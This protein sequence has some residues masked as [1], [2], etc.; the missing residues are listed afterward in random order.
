MLIFANIYYRAD[1]LPL[2]L[3]LFIGLLSAVAL[4]LV[5]DALMWALDGLAGTLL[6]IVTVFYYIL[7]S[8][9]CLLWYLYVEYYIHRDT[10]RLKKRLFP[11]L[12]PT[13]I[14]LVFSLMS[15]FGDFL[16]YID[17]D[18]VYHRGRLFFL[19]V[20][21]SLFYII[22]TII[23][24]IRC[25]KF[26][27]K[28]DIIPLNIFMIPPAVGAVLQSMYF[29][30]SLIWPL[31]TLSM[32]NIFIRLQNKQLF[33]DPLT[34]LFNRRQLERYMRNT[35]QS[36]NSGILGGLMIDLNSFKKIND[37]YGH[38]A[39]DQALI[40]T[41]EILKKTFRKNDFIA[42]YGGDEFIVVIDIDQKSD[43]KKAVERLNDN[44]AQFNNRKTAFYTISLSIG[45]DFYFDKST[46]DVRGFIK[47]LDKLMYEN[48]HN[49][50]A[51]NR[52]A[53]KTIDGYLNGKEHADN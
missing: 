8:A 6:G 46:Y 23:I 26:I 12:I 50:T 24:T 33:T 22:Y 45:Y 49:N 43:L 10:S 19:M 16:F 53:D 9:I 44:V 2:D 41:S 15:L 32:L 17:G 27:R 3:K 25:R 20:A 30:L 37:I 1:R 29:G 39:G 52:I 4:I 36:N 48:K 28:Q 51:Q 14:I 40:D 5:A 42:R 7:S 35:V 13:V 31:T 21:S 38:D 34:G 18:N 47:H 11:M